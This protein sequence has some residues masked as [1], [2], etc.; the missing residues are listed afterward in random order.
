MK[1]DLQQQFREFLRDCERDILKAIP[2]IFPVESPMYKPITWKRRW[3]TVYLKGNQNE[4][5]T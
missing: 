3:G 1:K 4:N 5:T 2:I